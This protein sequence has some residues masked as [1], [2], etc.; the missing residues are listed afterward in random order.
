MSIEPQNTMET[1]DRQLPSALVYEPV[2]RTVDRHNTANHLAIYVLRQ[3]RR[4]IPK[5]AFRPR[6]GYLG[7][8]CSIPIDILYEVLKYVHPID[9][10]H[11][12]QANRAFQALLSHPDSS[13]AWT[14]ASEN[15]PALPK[16]PPVTP[17]FP[18]KMSGLEWAGLLFGRLVCQDCG[19]GDA[20]AN[21]PFRRFQCFDCPQSSEN[22]RLVDSVC[23]TESPIR[24]TLVRKSQ[25]LQ[26][27]ESGC[28]AE[29][30]DWYLYSEAEMNAADEAILGYEDAIVRKKPGAKEAYDAYIA[31]R[32]AEV[33]PIN[34]HAAT[35][36][37]WV[38]ELR[39]CY[40]KD[41]KRREL[42]TIK[43]ARR[44]FKRLGY[45]AEDISKATF[46]IEFED[47]RYLNAPR[48]SNKRWEV[49]KC[50]LE[51]YVIQAKNERRTAI[52]INARKKNR[53]RAVSEY[54]K[55]VPPFS[56]MGVPSSALRCLR[57]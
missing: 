45:H 37:R 56:N 44:R 33:D 46:E 30:D 47:V 35:C 20:P 2:V 55:S 38:E 40:V 14:L 57:V 1:E 16:C 29:A 48:L 52:H 15:D 18:T 27:W 50:R 54:M 9:L 49:I 23:G 32:R 34:E 21:I 13:L 41:L 5:V 10:Y 3:W 4:S 51:P 53:A 25:V 7:S 39:E 6:V 31:K 17:D 22:D 11:I 26:L 19:E 24:Y 12:S 42:K 43:R 36:L 8:I 28:T